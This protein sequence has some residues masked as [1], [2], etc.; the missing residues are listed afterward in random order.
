MDTTQFGGTFWIAIGSMVLGFLGLTGVYCLKAKCS[1]ISIC[2]GL[3]TIKRDVAAEL[4]EN[5]LEINHGMNP[6]SFQPV[7]FNPSSGQPSSG[8]IPSPAPMSPK[9]TPPASIPPS[10]Q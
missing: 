9:Q 8:Q 3:I 1:T 6:Y 2:W 5:D 7:N 10:S 4:Q